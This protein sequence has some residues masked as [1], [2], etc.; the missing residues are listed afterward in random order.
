VPAVFT[1]IVKLQTV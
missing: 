1:T